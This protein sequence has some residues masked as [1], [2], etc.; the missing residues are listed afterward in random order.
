MT[1]PAGAVTFA[2]G[3]DPGV[4]PELCRRSVVT[5]TTGASQTEFGFTGEQYGE[6]GDSFGYRKRIKS[7]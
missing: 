6:Y 7:H 2:R 5:Y 3:Y 4:Y 1:D